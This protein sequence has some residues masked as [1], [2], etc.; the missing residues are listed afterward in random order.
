MTRKVKFAA[1]G[2]LAFT[3]A[4]LVVAISPQLVSAQKLTSDSNTTDAAVIA[5]SNPQSGVVDSNTWR[6]TN[7]PTN[8]SNNKSGF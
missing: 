5:A 8:R 6:N 7:T 3:M 4:G 1:V 2:L